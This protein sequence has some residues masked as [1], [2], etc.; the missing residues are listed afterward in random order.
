MFSEALLDWSALSSDV[1]VDAAEASLELS[2]SAIVV[3]AEDACLSELLAQPLKAIVPARS[4]S[5]KFH[6]SFHNK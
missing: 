5:Q 4:S 2:V 3:S 6:R 1:S